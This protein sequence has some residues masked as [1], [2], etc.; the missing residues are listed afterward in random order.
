MTC[1]LDV[2]VLVALVDPLHIHHGAAHEWFEGEGEAGWATCPITQ[3]G[4]LR[5]VGS[6]SYTNPLRTPAAVAETLA[7]L[8]T[9]PGHEFWADDLSL[10][11]SPLVDVSQILGSKQVTDTYLLALARSRDG[12]L[13]TFDRRLS[14]SA[15]RDGTRTRLIIPDA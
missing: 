13:A 15:V 7:D 12:R 5:I 10:M 2:N 9:A 6:S 3:N 8:V 14:T 1:L 4:L 11:S